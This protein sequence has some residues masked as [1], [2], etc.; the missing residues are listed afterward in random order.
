MEMT[1]NTTEL[2]NI[3]DDRFEELNII[4][5]KMQNA[6]AENSRVAMDQTEYLKRYDSLKNRYEEAKAEFDKAE[7]QIKAKKSKRTLLK[8][9]MRTLEEAGNVVEE[10]DAGLWCS[11]VQEVVMQTDG[12]V[13]FVFKNGIEI[14][15]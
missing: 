6:I 2:E 1:C 11:L 10:F 15:E 5:D 13:R 3:R 12:G 4:S 7:E 8:G 9:V 14:I